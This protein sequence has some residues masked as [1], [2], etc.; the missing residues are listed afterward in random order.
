VP[1]H[2]R[3]SL[4]GR[5]DLHFHTP[6][7]FD[8]KNGSVTN[9]QIVE[10]LKKAGVSA[11]AI[12]DDH[13]IDVLRIRTLQKLG[14]NE[15]TV[16]PG[17]EFRTELGGKEKVH[18]IGIFSEDANLDELWTKLSGKLE[19]TPEDVK[20]T[21]H[22][23]IYVDFKE[24]AELIRNL[25]GIVSTHAG[26]KS[27]SIEN[28]GNNAVF[29]M[30]LKTDLA[31][32][33]VDIY[34]VGKLAD[35][36]GYEQV[37][38]PAIGKVLPLIMG[39][40]N[41][42]ITHYEVKAT[43]WIKG[44]P[45]FRTFQQLIS[46]PQR[47]FL[48]ETPVETVR[49]DGNPTKYVS[50]IQFVKKSGSKFDEDWFSG[51]VKLNPGLVAI[52]GNK[53]SGKTALAEAIGLLGNCTSADAFSFLNEKK[54]RQ[55]RNN[56]AKEFQATLTWRSEHTSTRSLDA[57]TDENAPAAVSYIPQSYLELICNEV[58]NQPGGAFDKELKSVIFSHVSED[59]K[60]GTESLDALLAFQTEPLQQRLEA[61]RGELADLNRSILELEQRSSNTNRQ[62]LLGLKESKDRELEAHEKI[63]PEEVTK[64]DMDPAQQETLN[65]VSEQIA[66]VNQQRDGLNEA[67][68][69][70]EAAQRTDATKSASAARVLQQL[71]N[72][73]AAH[74]TLLTNLKADCDVLGLDPKSLV[75]VIV[76]DKPVRDADTA[77]KA[78]SQQ[79]AGVIKTA[80]GSLDELK[81]EVERLTAELDAPN[82]AYQKYVEA[83]R[84]WTERR[85][86]LIGTTEK[87][88]SLS[89]IERQ[90]KELAGLPEQL[91]QAEEA[92]AAKVKEIFEQIQEIVLTYRKLYHPVQEFILLNPVAN[93]KLHLE[94]DAS[95]VPVNLDETI[96]SKVNQGRRGSFAGVE[97]GKRALKAIVDTADLQTAVGALAFAKTLL[98]RFRADY[99]QSPPPALEL[100]EQLKSGATPLELLDAIFGLKYLSPKYQL[101]WSGKSIEELSPGERGTLL[102]IFYLL[103]DRRDV[104]L[105][106]DQPED[107]LDNQ[108]VYDMLVACLREA[109]R[110][111][112]VI[113][114]THN[115]NL[116]VV[117][118]ADQ[119]IHSHIDKQHKNKVTYTSG[120]LE[121]PKT[122]TLSITVLE[123]TRP[124]FVQ[125]DRKY[126]EET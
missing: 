34:E 67:V 105:I 39:S 59:K 70:A 82:S 110:R 99:R 97:E 123:G 113:I 31:R 90:I 54:F 22:E 55:P 4:W 94:F 23:A 63:K 15:L 101:K 120:S 95:I 32:E 116:A 33:C 88:D 40:D 96:L 44:D 52:I 98:A 109:R 86:G 43:C 58:N 53:G 48:G 92:R 38:F 68:R 74:R 37:V 80:T 28:I 46:D 119:I 117:C 35:R 71:R 65:K 121:N 20:K 42:D 57:S 2:D 64:P 62:M 77:A 36:K 56:K 73:E 11:V 104:P 87:R 10:G 84:T 17:I 124:A 69:A 108:T 26:G 122:N 102:L 27:N 3:G 24:A 103:I 51:V 16:L 41:H 45:S 60:L 21:T 100:G 114:V 30:A 13:V 5:W 91:K 18:L 75:S 7:S 9:E 47:A 81:G 19:L 76:T 106:I 61:L 126:H 112:Q 29:K 115:P 49:I 12:T 1:F 6:T 85:E 78:D 25:G 8:Y 14:G 50:E 89:Y 111:R 118:D 125:R 93:Q 72:F 66:T 107:N 79:Q 83:L